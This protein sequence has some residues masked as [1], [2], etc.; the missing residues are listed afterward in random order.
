MCDSSTT[1]RGFSC[2]GR[3]TYLL[4]LEAKLA[5][6]QNLRNL[7]RTPWSNVEDAL[8]PR[9]SS[10][11]LVAVHAL[12]PSECQ[13]EPQPG[14]SLI[15]PGEGLALRQAPSKAASQSIGTLRARTRTRTTTKPRRKRVQ[16]DPSGYYARGTCRWTLF[17]WYYFFWKREAPY[18]PTIFRPSA[19]L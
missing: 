7:M 4:K 1:T 8:K 9:P 2:L 18:V 13:Q 19:L 16:E 17:L 15:L 11:L 5:P 14:V 6:G 12:A 3:V 10:A